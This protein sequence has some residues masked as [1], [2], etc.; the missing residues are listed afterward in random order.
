M[1]QFRYNDNEISF[2]RH[3][4]GYNYISSREAGKLIEN[5]QIN[6]FMRKCYVSIW[7]DNDNSV[8]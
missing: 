3:S 2:G 4:L 7:N 8:L 6:K 5:K 1:Y